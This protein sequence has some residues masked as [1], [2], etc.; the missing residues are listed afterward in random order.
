MYV[1]ARVI[2]AACRLHYPGARLEIQ[3]LDDSTDETREIVAREVERWRAEGRDIHHL[4]RTDRKGFKAGALAA[5]LERARGE[6]IAVFDADFV[7]TPDFLLQTV[8]FFTDPVTG[9]RL[10]MV[11]ARWEHIN[12]GYSLLTRIQ[13]IL[14]D[15]HFLI[16]HTAR[17]RGG[18]FFNFNGTAGVWRREVIA[19]AGGWEHDTLTEDLDLSYRAQLAGWRFL[20]LPDLGVP[21]ELPVDIQGFKSQQYRWARGSIQTGKKLLPRLLAAELPWKVKREALIHLT[22]NGSYLLMIALSLLVFP[23][24]MAR[25]ASSS[26]L[27]VAIDLPLFLAASLSVLAFYVSSQ[28][29]RGGGWYREIKYLPG[30]MGLGIGLSVNNARAVLA[31]LRRQG[32]VFHR[33]PKYRI[34]RRGEGWR[35]K[36]YR[37]LP[38]RLVVVELLLALYLGACLVAAIGRGMWLSLPFLY[39][40]FHGFT[41][42]VVLNLLGRRPGRRHPPMSAALERPT[43]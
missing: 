5:G 17:H 40:F 24:M 29:A 39:L 13:A 19:D 30:L 42:V 18:C 15:G 6:L 16:E 36:C 2:E 12:R 21:S 41:Y 35:D 43:A 3:V 14:L 8:P 23:A 33:T 4:H 34:E 37:A 27:L 22:N 31:G 38:D 20:Y 28:V 9:D 1:A 7:P 25:Q 32:G 10:G 26:W 11:Q